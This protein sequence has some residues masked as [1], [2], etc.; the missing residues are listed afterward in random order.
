MKSR[1]TALAL[2]WVTLTIVGCAAGVTQSGSSN[3]SG[4]SA[5]SGLL[6]IV[7][8]EG[9]T[10]PGPQRAGQT[11]SRPYEGEVTVSSSSAPAVQVTT[12]QD[13]TADVTLAEG[14]YTVGAPGSSG[15]LPRLTQPVTVTVVAG[16]T[17]TAT[18]DFDTGIR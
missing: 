2:V 4:T 18:L 15:G 1:T 12:S 17:T 6:H 5:P 7:A 16:A 8:T 11:C 10:C 3:G 9:P 14:T 13:G